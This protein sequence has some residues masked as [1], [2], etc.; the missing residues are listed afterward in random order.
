MKQSE[1]KELIVSVLGPS[2]KDEA[3]VSPEIAKDIECRKAA[4]E[5]LAR[6]LEYKG[7]EVPKYLLGSDW[8]EGYAGT[9][10]N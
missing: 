10:L 9:F 7:L 6:R 8:A 5:I 1:M 3:L 2:P 4:A